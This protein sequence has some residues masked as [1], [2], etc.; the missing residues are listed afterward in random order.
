LLGDHVRW[1]LGDD[2]GAVTAAAGEIVDG[3]KALSFRLARR[4]PF[5]PAPA[6]AGLSA[7][8]ARVI[9]GLVARVG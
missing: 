6:I 3:C 4:R 5:D 9:D 8:W 2:G 7:A 1:L